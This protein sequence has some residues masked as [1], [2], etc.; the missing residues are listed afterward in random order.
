[1]SVSSKSDERQLRSRVGVT[2][3]F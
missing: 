1:M 2:Y 3:S